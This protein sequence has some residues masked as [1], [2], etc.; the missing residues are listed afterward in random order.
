MDKITPNQSPL[1]IKKELYKE[2]LSSGSKKLIP[3]KN[4]NLSTLISAVKEI[5]VVT[6]YDAIDVEFA[7]IEKQLYILQVRPIAAK[8]NNVMCGV[9]FQNRFNQSIQLIKKT[10]D[11]G[12]FGKIVN[13]SLSL[14]WCRYQKYYSDQWHGTWKNDG[15]VM[16]QQ[17]IHHQSLQDIHY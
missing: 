16:N 15:G 14:L 17:L 1:S 12:R 5:E 3:I 10:L 6:K 8:K 9:I 11:K 7:F 2:V 4:E 13:V